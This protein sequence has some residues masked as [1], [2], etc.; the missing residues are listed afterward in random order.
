[1]EWHS[2]KIVIIYELGEMHSIEKKSTGLVKL[3]WGYLW[4]H[5]ENDKKLKPFK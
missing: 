2:Y 4:I 1:M 5:Q 3:I